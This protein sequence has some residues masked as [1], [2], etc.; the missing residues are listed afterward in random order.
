MLLGYN[1]YRMPSLGGY[2][3]LLIHQQVHLYNTCYVL[4]R[5][6]E[7]AKRQHALENFFKE[8]MGCKGKFGQVQTTSEYVRGLQKHWLF[9]Q[10]LCAH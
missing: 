1:N 8:H 6:G 9:H 2:R 5:C 10:L 7:L 4:K 3:A